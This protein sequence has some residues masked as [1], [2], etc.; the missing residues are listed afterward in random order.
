MNLAFKYAKMSADQNNAYGL[1][2]AGYCYENGEGVQE[3]KSMG[4][5]YYK[6]S[7]D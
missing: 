4:F 5:K 3:N 2:S 1:N 7:A 6:M